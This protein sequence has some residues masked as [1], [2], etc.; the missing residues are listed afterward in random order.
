MILKRPLPGVVKLLLSVAF[1]W[2]FMWVFTP[3]WVSKFPT[4]QRLAKLQDENGIPYGALYYNDLPYNMDASMEIRD[5]WR[6]PPRS[7]QN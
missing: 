2:F 1:I 3:F 7:S 5:S 4:Q 6:F